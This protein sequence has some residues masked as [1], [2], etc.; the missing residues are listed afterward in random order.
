MNKLLECQKGVVKAAV[1]SASPTEDA[2]YFQEI[3]RPREECKA[4]QHRKIP[5]QNCFLTQ[6][7]TCRPIVFC[8]YKLLWSLIKMIFIIIMSITVHLRNISCMLF[9][10]EHKKMQKRMP[11]THRDKT[12]LK[13]S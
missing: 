7:K 4:L 8:A 1:S 2:S 9:S 6:K 13:E 11:A 12:V 10:S 5:E 3:R